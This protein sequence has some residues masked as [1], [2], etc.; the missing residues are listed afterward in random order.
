V[1]GRSREPAALLRQVELVTTDE[2]ASAAD[3]TGKSQIARIIHDNGPRW[4]PFVGS[5]RRPS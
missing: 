3:G 5:L 4:P 1:I 2:R